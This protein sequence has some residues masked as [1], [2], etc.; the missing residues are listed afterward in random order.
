[1]DHVAMNRANWD[2]RVPV[3]ATSEAYDV[4]RLVTGERWLSTV[5]AH[6]QRYLG[7]VVGQ[8]LVH[9]QCHI[10]T[11]SLSLA[12]LG[13]EVTG[14]DFSAPA[15]EVAREIARRAGQEVTFVEG[16]LYEAAER[17]PNASFD[18]VYTSVGALIWLPDIAGWAR[19]VRRLLAPG[20][21][22]VVRDVHPVLQALDH[23]RD[24]DLLV[25]AE[26]YFERAEPVIFD[27]GGTYADADASFET[28]RTAEWNHSIGELLTAVLEAGLTLR[29]FEELTF[30]DWQPFALFEHDP[31]EG[32]YR[33]PEHL[34]DRL[35]TYVALVA[36]LDV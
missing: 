35:P 34:R 6:D 19:V 5:V 8:R 23:D 2:E 1:M 9:L 24:D 4:E 29:R 28:T 3:H 16:E 26:P 20:G 17:L 13:A 14:Y 25:L 27:E 10:G 31:E 33:L 12:R 32:V 18:V 22:L 30:T 11:D 7:D 15:L 36:T 21:R